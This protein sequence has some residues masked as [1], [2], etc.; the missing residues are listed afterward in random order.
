MVELGKTQQIG[1]T[2]AGAGF[3]AMILNI[4]VKFTPLKFGGYALLFL[5]VVYFVAGKQINKLFKIKD[6]DQ[7][8]YESLT[9][10][11]ILEMK[12]LEFQNK[13]YEA[14]QNLEIEKQKLEIEKVKAQ[15]NQLKTTTKSDSFP[16]ILGNISP[17]INEKPKQK[18]ETNLRD[19]M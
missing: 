19:L 3:A 16:D 5:G 8:R 1:L 6:K 10:A 9:P 18:K 7:E 2:I 15:I 11:Q 4:F 13:M 17:F 14:K 12:R